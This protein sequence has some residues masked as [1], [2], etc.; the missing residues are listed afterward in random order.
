VSFA[1]AG[2]LTAG[3][4]G[5]AGTTRVLAACAAGPCNDSYR[6]A[7]AAR[8]VVGQYAVRLELKLTQPRTATCTAFGFA[9]EL[10]V[11]TVSGWFVVTG[12][13]SSGTTGAATAQIVDVNLLVD[14]G[15][16]TLPT[17][18]IVD[19]TLATCSTTTGCP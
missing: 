2:T 7:S 3:S 9:V 1:R 12:Y 17:V 19:S 5:V 13:F 4:S 14:L 8:L 11:E 16:A 10:A 15:T 18:R 6:G